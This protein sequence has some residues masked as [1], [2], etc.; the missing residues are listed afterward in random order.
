MKTIRNS[1]HLSELCTLKTLLAA[2]KPNL[3]MRPSPTDRLDIDTL[4]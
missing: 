1:I 4:T 3:G 2:T